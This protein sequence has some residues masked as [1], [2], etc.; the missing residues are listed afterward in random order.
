MANWL[1]LLL[2]RLPLFLS[3][4]SQA[5]ES[6]KARP[7]NTFPLNPCGVN[8]STKLVFELY[9]LATPDSL[10]LTGTSIRIFDAKSLHAA[11]LLIRSGG[12]GG[13]SKRFFRVEPI[14]DTPSDDGLVFYADEGFLATV[15]NGV[16]T[17]TLPFYK[18][19]GNR[20]VV[21]PVVRRM[22]GLTFNQI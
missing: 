1:I 8:M 3:V 4:A 13:K 19:V 12:F 9:L 7:S 14:I 18:M 20:W 2:D 16:H 11:N 5:L 21:N 17:G 10:N 6:F 22:I 15:Y